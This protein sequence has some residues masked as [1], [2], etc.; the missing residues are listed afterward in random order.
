[1]EKAQVSRV[2]T[3][4]RSV[5][6]C[7]GILRGAL[8]QTQDWWDARY[9]YSC[10]HFHIWNARKILQNLDPC[11]KSCILQS[12]H[13]LTIQYSQFGTEKPDTNTRRGLWVAS[14]DMIGFIPHWLLSGV[15][16]VYFSGAGV[17]T[18]RLLRPTHPKTLW[19]VWEGAPALVSRH[20]R[21][22]PSPVYAK[23]ARFIFWSTLRKWI[24]WVI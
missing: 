24:I 19:S 11:Q 3:F 7:R 15:G 20:L 9:D 6:T 18:G 22:S 1:M 10:W 21:H 14:S 13:P 2:F 16:R 5:F 12:P 4:V 17:W 8:R 23:L